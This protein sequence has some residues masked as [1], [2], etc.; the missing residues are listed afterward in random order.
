MKER[1]T[2]D[3]CTA[4]LG[5]VLLC[6]GYNKGGKMK[7]ISWMGLWRAWGKDRRA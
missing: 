6:T 1:E 4:G 5:F 2:G 3:N 7:R